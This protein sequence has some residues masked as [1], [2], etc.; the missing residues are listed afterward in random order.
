MKYRITIT[1]DYRDWVLIK[2]ALEHRKFEN[3]QDIEKN[4]NHWNNDTL[5]DN[6]KRYDFMINE[7]RGYKPYFW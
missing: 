2:D 1:L 5:K 4:P 3:E 7:L 6:I